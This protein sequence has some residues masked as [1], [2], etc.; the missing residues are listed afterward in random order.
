VTGVRTWTHTVY[1]K[2][3]RADRASRPGASGQGEGAVAWTRNLYDAAGRQT[4]TVSDFDISGNAGIA[5]EGFE[6][7]GSGWDSGGSASFLSGGPGLISLG[8]ATGATVYTGISSLLVTADAA[9][10]GAEWTLPGT[11]QASHAYHLILWL[12]GPSGASLKTY[13]GV[14]GG[15][16]NSV[17]TSANGAWQKVDFTWTPSSAPTANTVKVA[18]ATTGGAAAFRI[19]DVSVWDTQARSGITNPNPANGPSSVTV[20]DAR[21]KVTESLAAPATPGDP[22]PA[23]V[24]VYDEMGRVA[25]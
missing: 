7:D 16:N 14:D 25:S 5:I 20:F 4:T 13:L 3:G 24:S 9:N 8:A 11:F 10:R 22:A 6:G 17:T 15:N 2:G 21:G 23:T 12:K 1:T 18:V 19:D